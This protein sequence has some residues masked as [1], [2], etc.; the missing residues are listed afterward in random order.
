MKI[1]QKRFF[2]PT[3]KN[4]FIQENLISCKPIRI[5]EVTFI[6]ND[7]FT[8]RYQTQEAN[9]GTQYPDIVE[10][11]ILWSSFLLTIWTILNIYLFVVNV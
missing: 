9:I 11:E 10:A 5:I 1:F 3:E 2:T 7:K 6:F 8:E 4:Q